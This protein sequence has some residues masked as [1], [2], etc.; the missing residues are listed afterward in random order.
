MS[1][2]AQ[3]AG[4]FRTDSEDTALFAYG[5]NRSSTNNLAQTLGA[6]TNLFEQGDGTNFQCVGKYQLGRTTAWS[7]TSISLATSAF[8]R[9]VMISLTEQTVYGISG[10]SSA[11]RMVNIRGGA[12]Q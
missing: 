3:G 10:G 8:W 12:D 5:H 9:T 1:W 2:A 6:L 7:G 11:P 4:L